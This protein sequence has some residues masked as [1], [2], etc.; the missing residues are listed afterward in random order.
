MPL[1]PKSVKEMYFYFDKEHFSCLVLPTEFPLHFHQQT[2][3]KEDNNNKRSRRVGPVFISQAPTTKRH[4]TTW[5]GMTLIYW[6]SS[7]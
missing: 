4:E 6:A 7:N 5:W 2:T 3:T 1:S